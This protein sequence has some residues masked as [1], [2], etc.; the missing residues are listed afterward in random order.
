MNPLFSGLLR[1]FRGLIT[2]R[3]ATPVKKRSGIKR[4][5]IDGRTGKNFFGRN[6]GENRASEQK[7]PCKDE[8]SLHPF[9]EMNM[10]FA[11]PTVIKSL[12]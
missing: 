8:K 11:V 2:N 5:E 4:K 7:G 10:I 1:F 12:L 6:G 9:F 3:Q